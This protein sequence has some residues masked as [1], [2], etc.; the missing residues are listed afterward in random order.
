[1]LMVITLMSVRFL[2]LFGEKVLVEMMAGALKVFLGYLM[3]CGCVNC[4][5]RS[6]S[7]KKKMEARHQKKPFLSRI[8]KINKK[9]KR[10][11]AHTDRMCHKIDEYLD[12]DLEITA[13]CDHCVKAKEKE[14]ENYVQMRI[15]EALR[16]DDSEAE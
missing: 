15:K 1:M 10:L 2:Y 12:K 16:D 8:L 7:Q 5:R 13:I 6:S 11:V 14:I 4:K 9:D 3:C